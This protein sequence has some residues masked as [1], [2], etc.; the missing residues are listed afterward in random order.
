M[1]TSQPTK[2][3]AEIL[4]EA[5]QF[6]NVALAIDHMHTAFRR[7]DELH[8]LAEVFQPPVAFFRLDR[9]LRGIYMALECLCSL[10]LR[11]CPEFCCCQ[12]K[13]RAFQS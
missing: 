1:N 12:S 9:N 2:A 7:A 4:R 8:R 10:I 11:A 13:R 5:E 6:V 3:R